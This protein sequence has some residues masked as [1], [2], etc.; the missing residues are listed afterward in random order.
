MR[1][2]FVLRAA[3]AA[4]VLVL[5]AAPAKAQLY[6]SVG[7]RGQGM[8]GA[9]V[10]VADDATAT[11][12]NPAGLA[13]GAYFNGII[14][15]GVAQQ[16]RDSRDAGGQPLAAWQSH[17]RGIALAFPA[18]GLSYYR[19]QIS[20]IQ[21]ITPTAGQPANRQDP[22][23]APRLRALVLNQ[24]G[25]TV[26]QSMGNHFVVGSTL[27][28]VRGSMVS[29]PVAA[30]DASF[31]RAESLSGNSETHADLDVGALAT[32]GAVRM[33]VA[34]KNLRAPEFGTGDDRQRLSRQARAGVAV[35]GHSRGA[36][37]QL[38]LAIDADLT[39]TETAV[40][41]ARHVAGGVEALTLKRRLGLRAGVSAN[42]IGESRVSLSS[43]AS[44]AVRSGA[45]FEGQ[46]TA[47]SDLARRGWGL[48]LRLTF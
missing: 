24:F 30:A 26:G 28:L 11:W 3:G 15:Y 23:T 48:G 7:I 22:G 37:D 10:A 6:E 27:K 44:L 43:G 21:P 31:D 35:I 45:Y 47:G 12:W 16:P 2:S 4:T 17:A 1:I 46:Y 19:L 34:V 13:T 32:F 14:E 38:A 5:A 25:A 36:V 18:L 29:A 40:G 8:G 41:K 42:T 33:G 20:E 9:F 39:T